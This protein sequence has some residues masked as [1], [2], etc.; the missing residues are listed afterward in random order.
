[1]CYPFLEKLEQANNKSV[2]IQLFSGPEVRGTRP[3]LVTFENFKDRETV[4]R[5][6]K[7]LKK[8]NIH[9]TEDLSRRTRESRYH[10]LGTLHNLCKTIGVFQTPHMHL[11]ACMLI[12]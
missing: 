5:L 9:V 12:L 4:L 8:A 6:A 3:V 2:P 1:M 11:H 10:I 7:V